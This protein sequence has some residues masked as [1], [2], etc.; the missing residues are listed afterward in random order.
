MAVILVIVAQVVVI[1]LQKVKGAR[2]VIPWF[3]RPKRYN[4]M[5][6]ISEVEDL[7]SGIIPYVRSRPLITMYSRNVPFA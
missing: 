1:A 3:L 6:A 4:Y 7:E 2:Y 5:R